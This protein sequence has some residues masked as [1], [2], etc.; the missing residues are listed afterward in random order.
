MGRGGGP[1][2]GAQSSGGQSP[3]LT[4]LVC[5]MP[6]SSSPLGVLLP[7][8]TSLLLSARLPADAWRRA[9]WARGP[10]FSWLLTVCPFSPTPPTLLRPG[11]VF[12]SQSYALPAPASLPH[13]HAAAVT[14]FSALYFM[15][16]ALYANYSQWQLPRD[17]TATA[18]TAQGP[19]RKD[20]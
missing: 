7:T 20:K 13:L 15:T 11:V 8:A 12:F 16:F 5:S 19:D 2:C 9:R 4:P 17:D 10:A 1:S 6:E 14:A 3:V 18:T